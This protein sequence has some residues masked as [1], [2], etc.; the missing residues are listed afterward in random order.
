MNAAG[1]VREPGLDRGVSPGAGVGRGVVYGHSYTAAYRYQL[2]IGKVGGWAIPYPLTIPQAVTGI[3]MVLVVMFTASWWY[4]LTGLG[5]A[6]IGVIAP[7]IGVRIVGQIRPEGRSVP[8]WLH[9]WLMAVCRQMQ[10][11]VVLHLGTPLTTVA[12]SI[13][14]PATAATGR[15][16]RRQRSGQPAAIRHKQAPGAGVATWDRD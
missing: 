7:F 9:G 11:G 3:A 4:P 5:G 10:S 14:A 13:A 6:L 8:D 2:V 16:A 12:S 1:M 15:A